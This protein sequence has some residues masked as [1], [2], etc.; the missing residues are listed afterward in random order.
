MYRPPRP[1][2]KGGQ[3]YVGSEGAETTWLTALKEV[4]PLEGVL[5][6]RAVFIKREKECQ[7]LILNGSFGS[8]TVPRRFAS[9]PAS[10]ALAATG[11]SDTHSAVPVEESEPVAKKTKTEGKEAVCCLDTVPTGR[12]GEDQSGWLQLFPEEILYLFRNGCLSA[13]PANSFS[14]LTFPD[15]WG[16]LV[17][18]DCR[19]AS[20]FITY[21]HLRSQ[22]WVV[23]HGLKFGTDFL[24]YISSPSHFHSSYAL[25]V[26][27]HSVLDPT[28]IPRPPVKEPVMEYQLVSEELKPSKEQSHK[29]YG[30]C[31]SGSFSG[32]ENIQPS[33]DIPRPFEQHPGPSKEF[34]NK[35]ADSPGSRP[36]GIGSP[37]LG[38]DCC[39]IPQ[40]SWRQ[41]VGMVRVNDAASKGLVICDVTPRVSLGQSLLTN[42]DVEKA[43]VAYTVV[44]RWLPEKMN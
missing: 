5:K 43:E 34:G 38:L 35:T 40:L 42:R 1:K 29:D 44:E 19:L 15:L 37:S 2:S 41:V 21:C 30:P 26:R 4:P 8:S 18:G 32:E 11:H 14:V 10:L 6:G 7:T 13:R 28:S 12:P 27:E 20:R 36:S 22:G 3:R 9:L 17:S 16:Q 33:E 31:T 24:L 25:T 39:T 23:K